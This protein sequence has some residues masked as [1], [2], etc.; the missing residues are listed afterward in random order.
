MG[1]GKQASMAR[2]EAGALVDGDGVPI[3]P[4]PERKP[5][6]ARFPDAP[7][8]RDIRF[9]I[10][11]GSAGWSRLPAAVQRRFSKRLGGEQVALYSGT[12]VETRLSRAGWWLAQL[13]RP[14]GAPLPLQRASG[15]P[16]MVCVSEDVASGGQIWSRLYGSGNGLPQ[17]IHSI[18]SFAGPTGLEEQIGFGIAM[19]LNVEARDDGLVFSSDHYACYAFGRRWRIPDWL[20]PGRTVVTHRDLGRDDRGQ[21]Q[22]A[23][24]LDVRHPLLGELLHQHALFSDQ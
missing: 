24:D 15:V 3:H 11:V 21:G 9:R 7:G 14:L 6:F 2:R 4:R 12:V 22:F 13:L 17:V 1:W 20:T 23:F 19:A 5:C 8:P 18:K 10:L 16:A